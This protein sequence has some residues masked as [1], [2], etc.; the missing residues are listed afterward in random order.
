M[1]WRNPCTFTDISQMCP[2]LVCLYN[3][4]IEFLLNFNF[5]LILY[6]LYIFLLYSV[7]VWFPRCIRTDSAGGTREC[8]NSEQLFVTHFFYHICFIPL[9]THLFWPTLFGAIDLDPL[10][11]HNFIYLFFYNINLPII[12]VHTFLLSLFVTSLYSAHFPDPTCFSSLFTQSFLT[13]S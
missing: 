7:V 13:Q 12:F 5:Y 8:P 3:V 1:R 10:F 4:F 9:F 11:V 2:V 6:L